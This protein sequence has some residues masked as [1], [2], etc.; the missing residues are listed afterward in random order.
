MTTQIQRRR[1]TTTQHGSFTGAVGEITIDTTKDTVVVHDGSTAGGHPL[2]KENNPTFTGGM[3]ID[4]GNL[5]FGN[6]SASSPYPEQKLKW[7]NDSTTASGFYIS[8]DTG[9]NGRV[10]HE[11][12][13][14]ILFGTSNTERM[15]LDVNGNL[16][17]GTSSPTSLG[18]GFKEVIVSGGT[19]GAGL[20]LQ[21]TDGNVKAGLFTSDISG[22]AYVRTITNHP[23]AFRTNNTERLRIDSSGNVGIGTTSPNAL[24]QVGETSV[25][26]ARAIRIK[27]NDNTG[28]AV[29]AQLELLTNQG[30]STIGATNPGNI[31]LS[32]AGNKVG[33]GTTSPAKLLHVS[34]SGTQAIRL[35]NTAGTGNAVLELK[36]PSNTFSA[37]I[38]STAI[39]YD[40]TAGNPYVW[41]QNGAERMR[42]NYQGRLGIGVS[43]PAATLDVQDLIRIRKN[44]SNR[45]TLEFQ[46]NSTRIEYSDQSG[47]L[48]FY[49][50]SSRR[51]FVGYLGG[52]NIVSGGLTMNAGNIS[53]S[54]ADRSIINNDNNALTFGTNATERMRIAN[55]G[56][57]AIGTTTA[58]SDLHVKS[59]SA[60]SSA[61]RIQRNGSASSNGDEYGALLFEGGSYSGGKISSHR[62]HGTWDDRGDLRFSTGYGNSVFTERMRI[63]NVGGCVVHASSGNNVI[64]AK[65]PDSAGTSTRVF[66]AEHSAS[67]ITSSGTISFNV[68]SNGNVQNTNNSYGA[69]SDVKLKENIVDANSQWSDIKGIRVRN[70]NFIEGQTHT[71]LGV[72]AQEVE[73]VS[74]GLV[75]ES[76]DLDAE[77]N[78][79]GTTTKS[80]NYSVLY[81][82]AVKALQEAMDRIETLETKVA[83]LEA[84]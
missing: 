39:Y 65:T 22:A 28:T 67:T 54:G 63:Y 21:D 25:N 49:T 17:I 31:I 38:N 24:L 29:K 36:L 47:N 4:S 27:N 68:Y 64:R 78:D 5:L 8:Q 72:V 55:S 76:P 62:D 3:S 59:A 80:V 34:G 70:Y 48:E 66:F 42:L 14:E 11:Q 10:W 71:Q 18:S 75:T 57:V 61:I 74:P 58:E 79:L 30:T 50:N 40:D 84:G 13:L 32:P 81:M 83:A 46:A 12:G 82:K 19:E 6:E 56:R 23:L 41:Y 73:T 44:A 77:G 1:G 37:G 43:A 7:S 51:A 20:Q 33:I 35:E 15:R 52:F 16:G 53:L 69:I 2:A 60:G 45:A 26:S 9:R